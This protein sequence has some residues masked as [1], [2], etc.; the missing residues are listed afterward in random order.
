MASLPDPDQPRRVGNETL[1]RRVGVLGQEVEEVAKFLGRVSRSGV[2][3][4][5]REDE[6]HRGDQERRCK[7]GRIAHG[8]FASEERER[9]KDKNRIP[10][11]VEDVDP[12]RRR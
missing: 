10:E 6:K 8:K 9:T 12:S 7:T 2:A 1:A 11:D 4:D 3:Q 5:D